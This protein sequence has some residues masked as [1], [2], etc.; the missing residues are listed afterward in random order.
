M[1]NNAIGTG[2][3]LPQSDAGGW[4]GV[5]FNIC[6]LL[7]YYFTYHLIIKES[8]TVDS[9]GLSSPLLF[10][11]TLALIVLLSLITEPFAIFYKLSYENYSVKGRPLKLPGFFLFI[12]V[13]S[14]FFVRLVF[15]IAALESLNINPAN[16]STGAIIVGTFIF[17]ME[18]KYAAV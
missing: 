3:I 11:T 10:S 18:N 7:Y 13:A 16:G 9:Y 12:M 14:R 2:N 8:Y 5:I 1:G 6:F 15:F 17:V 4:K